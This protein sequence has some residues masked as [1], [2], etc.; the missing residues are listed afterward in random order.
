VADP[1]R[2]RSFFSWL[3]DV[4]CGLASY[5]LSRWI[6]QKHG[7]GVFEHLPEE[8]GTFALIYILLKLTLKTIGVARRNRKA[9]KALQRT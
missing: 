2:R 9:A 4:F 3:G 7:G 5:T 8:L 6:W 1:S